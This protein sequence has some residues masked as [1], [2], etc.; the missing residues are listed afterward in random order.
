MTVTRLLQDADIKAAEAMRK[1]ESVVKE[2]LEATAVYAQV[3]AAVEAA[4]RSLKAL[5]AG[6]EESDASESED[7]AEAAQVRAT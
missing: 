6:D 7:E 2:E 3:K 5:S 1:T 4:E